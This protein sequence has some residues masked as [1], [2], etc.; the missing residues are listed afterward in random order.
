MDAKSRRWI[1]ITSLVVFCVLAAGRLAT[2][3]TDGQTFLI[4]LLVVVLIGACVFPWLVRRLTKV[5]ANARTH[6][7]GAVVIPG[8]TASEMLDVARAAGASTAGIASQGGSPVAIVVLPHAYEVWVRTESAPRWSVP[9]GPSTEVGVLPGVYGSRSVPSV[10]V[11]VEGYP[12]LVVIP[13]YRPL[14]NSAGSDQA[15]IERALVEL[16][17][18]SVAPHAAS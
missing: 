3:G 2:N 18:A 7:P 16:G 9:R 12:G 6:R 11:L 13:A 15:G 1:W 10:A 17:G 5:V 8:Y 14:R 4:A